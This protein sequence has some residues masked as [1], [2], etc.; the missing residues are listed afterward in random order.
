MPAKS[1]KQRKMMGADLA[2]LRAGKKTKTGMTEVQ[3]RKCASK[4]IKVKLFKHLKAPASFE[5]DVSDDDVDLMD[6]VLE[7]I[8][9]QN[10]QEFQEL[11]LA[12]VT[13]HKT[14]FYEAIQVALKIVAKDNQQAFFDEVE[15]EQYTK[16]DGTQVEAHTRSGTPAKEEVVTDKKSL[17]K[18][19]NYTGRDARAA[20]RLP[21]NRGIEKLGLQEFKQH[22]EGRSPDDWFAPEKLSPEQ[23]HIYRQWQAEEH[24]EKWKD[25]DDPKKFPPVDFSLPKQAPVKKKKSKIID[26]VKKFP[27]KALKTMSKSLEKD[28]YTPSQAKV[29]MGVAAGAGFIPPKI[30]KKAINKV[31]ALRKSKTQK[32]ITRGEKGLAEPV[33]ET[34]KP[35]KPWKEMNIFEKVWS[36]VWSR[37]NETEL[38]ARTRETQLKQEKK[39]A[40]LPQAE[41]AA[42][43]LRKKARKGEYKPEQLSAAMSEAPSWEIS[44]WNDAQIHHAL[45]GEYP[46]MFQMPPQEQSGG[47]G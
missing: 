3:L 16:A 36:K 25:V 44:P 41:K 32:T 38:Y 18:E 45:F 28:G 21:Q 9:E 40:R 13:E 12:E 31:K 20:D 37:R 11:F 2:R 14:D 39:K 34:D 33:G 10:R 7:K 6:S 24:W 47:G 8:P 43:F 5:E 46:A 1:E 15:V 19:F 35:N 17:R 29:I 42:G 30:S 27:K 22:L 26:A 23:M 4:P